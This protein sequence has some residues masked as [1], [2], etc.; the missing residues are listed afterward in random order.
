MSVFGTGS[1]RVQECV[2]ASRLGFLMKDGPVNLYCVY[3][4]GKGRH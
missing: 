4:I 1:A 3:H 2:S